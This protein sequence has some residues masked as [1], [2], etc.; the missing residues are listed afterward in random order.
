MR[1]LCTILL[2]AVLAACSSN[3]EERPAGPLSLAHKLDFS[4][5]LSR[6]AQTRGCV[7]PIDT[8]RL[9]QQDAGFGVFAYTTSHTPYADFRLQNASDRRLP[10]FINHQLIRWNAAKGEWQ[11]ADSG[12]NSEWPKDE[13]S[14]VSF[15]AYAPY[16]ADAVIA[17]S[18][19]ECFDPAVRHTLA[20]ALET[21]VDLLWATAT[22][23]GV[24]LVTR[25]PFPVNADQTYTDN[26]GMVS[27]LFKHALAKLGGPYT[28]IDDTGADN[29]L[30]T[31][32]NGLMVV[33]DI[34]SN[35][36]NPKEDLN[37]TLE[38]FNGSTGADS[39]TPYN[40]KITI[41]SIRMESA[42]QLTPAGLALLLA[43]STA[44]AFDYDAH[45]EPLYNTGVL[46]LATGQWTHHAF[47]PS[48]ATLRSQL[49]L[50]Q[51][52]QS[53]SLHPNICEPADW[54][55]AHTEAAFKSLPIGV[56]TVP[57]NVY[58]YQ[59]DDLPLLFLP[60]THPVITFT[61]DY[62]VRTFDPKLARAYSEVRQAITKRLYI[63]DALELNKHYN[64]LL[65]IG[66]TSIKF[67]A[68]VEDWA[69]SASGSGV[70]V[71]VGD[72]EVSHVYLPA[73][74]E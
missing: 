38:P 26:E 2:V 31:L 70:D 20:P 74:V 73:N 47:T 12:A 52:P 58:A 35:L 7:G 55:N 16:S 42:R 62:T 27:I 8:E 24:T 50:P 65:H 69:A 33:L 21:Q 59:Q 56:T 9:K 67:T 22:K 19:T 13:Q 51:N 10:D 40:T 36:E 28:G 18:L 66:L 23:G 44:D 4:V 25:Q 3:V 71:Q 45:T 63:L 43:D 15:F 1:T 37:A 60:G 48:G 46:N 32:T 41:N 14:L 6:A 39:Q 17:S 30:T 29:D 68:Q 34:D 11:F 49:L 64:I 72:E 53:L 61:L 57:K 5:Y 54:S